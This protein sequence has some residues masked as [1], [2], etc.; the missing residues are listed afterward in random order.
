SLLELGLRLDWDEVISDVSI[1]PRLSF[2]HILTEDGE[3]KI[4]GGVGLY[5]D[6][7]NLNLITRPLD[8]RRVDFFYGEDG[9]TL[10]R[11]PLETVFL[12]NE[13]ELKPPRFL[14]WSL[15]VEHKLPAAIYLRAEFLQR[16]G[17]NGFTFVDLARGV[18]ALRNDRRDRY[19]SLQITL[20]R[21]FRGGYTAMAS[22][23]RSRARSNAV[24][25]F[26]LDN[27]IF[28]GQAG[29]PLPW[30]TPNRLISTG[31]L[32]L[33]RGYDLGYSLEWRD[34]YPFSVINDN[35]QLVEPPNS[36]RFPAFFSLNTHVEK[37]FV[38]KSYKWALRVGFNNVTN[39][40]NPTAVNNNIAS[41]EFL[42]FGGLQDRA[43]TG[44]IRFL[45]R[46]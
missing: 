3:T 21:A 46:R 34:G 15:G 14:N 33:G 2:S 29:G 9:Q 1:S 30:D 10:A 25:E 32:P 20:R 38:F 16:R 40:R 11:P 45:G 17:R 37:R 26:D 19:D 8:G 41:P 7:T 43:F 4:A 12:V 23:T 44:R 18:F 31:W 39:R 36:R 27:P 22:Y 28:S 5:Y 24:F 42:T 6:A 35:Q 13:E